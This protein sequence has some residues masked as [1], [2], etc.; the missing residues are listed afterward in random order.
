MGETFQERHHAIQAGEIG[1]DTF[2]SQV[3]IRPHVLLRILNQGYTLLWT[4][5][6]MVWLRNP[7]PSLPDMEGQEGVSSMADTQNAPRLWSVDRQCLASYPLSISAVVGWLGLNEG[8]VPLSQ[9]C[10]G[11]YMFPPG[12]RLILSLTAHKQK[13]AKIG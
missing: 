10:A 6:D 12:L 1:G 7:L 8:R 4:D 11:V 5:S 9:N 2:K 13:C 3:L